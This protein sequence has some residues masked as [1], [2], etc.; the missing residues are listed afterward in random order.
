[1]SLTKK[2]TRFVKSKTTPIFIRG[3][4]K[5]SQAEI[6]KWQKLTDKCVTTIFERTT[7]GY[8]N[9]VLRHKVRWTP[10]PRWPKGEV[11]ERN[12]DGYN[13]VSYGVNIL[14]IWL[15]ESG[16]TEMYPALID[17]MRKTI[18]RITNIGDDLTL[19]NDLCF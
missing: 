1:M 17:D 16:F 13:L 11:I 3:R 10:P 12:V 14:L 8:G 4:K 15:N 2:K 6:D 18:V 9:L 19:E 7:A 5:P